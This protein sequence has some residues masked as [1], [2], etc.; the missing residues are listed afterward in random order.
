MT[1]QEKEL[2]RFTRRS[3]KTLSNWNEWNDAYNQQLDNHAKAG[4]FGKPIER[5]D[6]PPKQQRQICQLQWTN[7]VKPVV[8]ASAAHV[9]MVPPEQLH[10]YAKM[11]LRMPPALNNLE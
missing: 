5:K 6:L 8:N 7:V 4:V 1:D 10:G 2:E 11:C 3:L 9:W